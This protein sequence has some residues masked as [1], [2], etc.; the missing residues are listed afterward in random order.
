VRASYPTMAIAPAKFYEN[1]GFG[2]FD[3]PMCFLL[4]CIA[5]R[6]WACQMLYQRPVRREPHG[7]PESGRVHNITTRP[8]GRHLRWFVAKR[9]GGCGHPPDTKQP[10]CVR[11]ARTSL[12]SLPLHKGAFFVCYQL[13]LA[14]GS[15]FYDVNCCLYKG[16]VLLFRHIVNA[17]PYNYARLILYKIEK[18][19]SIL[20]GETAKKL[21]VRYIG[22]TS[23]RSEF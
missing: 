12:N 14:Q 7:M 17:V 2:V 6:F 9:R 19:F 4:N 1:V 23:K 20:R 3:E 11:E 15:R 18:H 5:R 10:P 16:A 8:G 22:T 13:S 21:V